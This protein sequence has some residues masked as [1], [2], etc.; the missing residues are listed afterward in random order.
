[1]IRAFFVRSMAAAVAAASCARGVAAA[2][3]ADAFA[4]FERE[5]GGRLGVAALDTGSG[6]RVG[7]RADERFA[8]CSTFKLPLVAAVLARV[9]A[10]Q[11]RL[12]RFVPYGPADLLKYAPVTRA[13][14]AAGGMTIEALC[15]AAIEVSDNTAGNLLLRAVGGPAGLTR[16]ARSLGDAVTRFDRTE[17]TLNTAI[18][19]DPRDTTTPAAMVALANHILVGDALSRAS[20]TLLLHWLRACTTGGARIR[21]G[22]PH[23]WSAGDKTGTGDRA[24]TNDVAIAWPPQRRPLLIAEYYVESPASTAQ[25]EAVLAGSARVVVRALGA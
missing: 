3:N 15:A 25:R 20:R 14:V 5:R 18:P 13:H 19:G 9:D 11:E 12:D 22:L 8:M 10:G 21:A 17:P 16:Y 7:H 6:R 4:A 2:A 24:A 1:M 23:G